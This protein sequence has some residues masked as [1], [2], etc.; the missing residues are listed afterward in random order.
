MQATCCLNLLT[1]KR[2]ILVRIAQQTV[3]SRSDLARRNRVNHIIQHYTDVC[4]VSG[5][6]RCCGEVD[7]DVDVDE[8]T[9]EAGVT[10]AGITYEQSLEIADGTAEQRVT[11]VGRPVVAV[12][13]AVV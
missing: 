8:T 6:V 5:R 12:L 9:K 1:H 13:V 11:K 10:G 7:V 3:L 2:N 4:L